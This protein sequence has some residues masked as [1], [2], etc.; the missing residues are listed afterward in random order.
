[1]VFLPDATDDD[2]RQLEEQLE[3]NRSKLVVLHHAATCPYDDPLNCP[4]ERRCCAAKRLFVHINGCSNTIHCD[5]PGCNHSRSV[6]KHYRNCRHNTPEQHE[7]CM[8]CSSVPAPYNPASLC[9]QFRVPA[10]HK[11][12]GGDSMIP[13]AGSQYHDDSSVKRPQQQQQQQQD[14]HKEPPPQGVMVGHGPRRTQSL[15]TNNNVPTTLASK[16]AMAKLKGSIIDD[17]TVFS[18]KSMYKF[19]DQHLPSRQ[20][21]PLDTEKENTRNPAV[22]R[23]AATTTVPGCVMDAFGTL[24]GS[25]N[26]ST[27]EQTQPTNHQKSMQSLSRHSEASGR[28]LSRYHPLDGKKK[29]VGGFLSLRRTLSRDNNEEAA[30]PIMMVPTDEEDDN[31]EDGWRGNTTP[32]TVATQNSSLERRESRMRRMQRRFLT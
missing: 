25:S 16:K 6:W 7:A 19:P 14:A 18:R 28:K 11:H 26:T 29:G 2:Y 13:T 9:A 8:I 21:S 22:S 15:N 17:G 3:R 12:E 30:Q 1:M 32:L 27:A 10:A 23:P 24:W 20:P 5:V 4:L 31:E